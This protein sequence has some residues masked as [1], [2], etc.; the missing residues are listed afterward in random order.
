MSNAIWLFAE[1][2]DGLPTSLTCELAT[3]ARGLCDEVRA[4]SAEE[5][6]P[7]A[8]TLLGSYGVG[9]ISVVEVGTDA[10]PAVHIASALARAIEAEGAPDAVLFAATGDGR[11]AAGRLSACLDRPVLANVIGLERRS[12]EL[13]SLHSIFG[14]TKSVASRFTGDH[15]GIFIV[16]S[17]SF[18]ASPAGTPPAEVLHVDKSEIAAT[19]AA[20]VTARH[21]EARTGPSL[22]EARV[23]VSGGRGLGSPE[24]YVLIEQLAA[25]LSGAPGASRAIVDA[26]WVPYAKQVGQ[27]GKTVKPDLY[28]AVG[29]SGATQHLVG[30]KGSKCIIAINRDPEAPIFN[31]VDLGVVADAPTLLPR[32]LDALER[33]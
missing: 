10:M 12:G 23:V 1:F 31:I 33:Q 25:A 29:I 4:F 22:D 17:K 19:D 18:V 8:A 7:D 32:L 6:T 20:R 9:S 24:R 11:D 15:P 30:M 5:A 2:R 21:V 3:A 16:R 13:V 27:T 26:G 14:G 28:I